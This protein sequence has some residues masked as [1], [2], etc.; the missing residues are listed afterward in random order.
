M[1]KFYILGTYAIPAL[2]G[3]MS[4]PDSD[5]SA[6]ITQFVESMGGSV[7]CLLYTSPSPRDRV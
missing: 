6:A 5:R 1:S 7:S 2:T 3:M 4:N